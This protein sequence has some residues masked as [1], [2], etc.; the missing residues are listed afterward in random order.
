MVLR[1]LAVA[2]LSAGVML[3][4][5]SHALAVKEVQTKSA[6]GEPFRAEVELT[7]LGDL[8]ANEIR[9]TLASA[10]DFERMGIDRVFF[11]NDLRFDVEVNPGG[12]SFIRITSAKPV[13]EPYLDFV[14][15]IAW[16]GN[17]RLQEVT[18][19]LDPPLIADSAPA[20]IEAPAAA[21]P[22]PTPVP[23]PAP[24]PAPEAAPTSE[25]PAPVVAQ[26]QPRP[27]PAPAPVAPS[28]PVA[29]RPVPVVQPDSYHV[30]AGDT[31]ARIA[32][33]FRGGAS[34]G[35][36][37]IALQ[38]ANPAAFANNNIN[39][40]KRGQVLRIPSEEQMREVSAQEA[41]ASL[42]EQT[43]RWRATVAKAAPKPA[44][45]AAQVD[46][47]AKAEAPKAAPAPASK[48]EMKLLGAEA[49]KAGA[50]TSGK[51]KP[52][53]TKPADA[54][55]LGQVKAQ[56]DSAKAEKEKLAGKVQTLDAKV[57]TNDQKVNVQN[58]RL[59]QLESQLKDAQA[60]A[61][62]TKAEATKAAA[63][64]A[65]ADKAAAAK[66]E[67]DKAAAAKA[68]ADKAAA[69]KAEAD[70]AA[71]DKASADNAAATASPEAQADAAAPAA[72]PVPAP[73]PAPAPAPV[74]AEEP[75]VE[76]SGPLGLII[77]GIAALLAAGGAGWWW[78]RR[79]KE[80]EEAEATLAELES[81]DD[82]AAAEQDG[83][84]AALAQPATEEL[85]DS[86]LAAAEPAAPAAAA[87]RVLADP[88]EE[89]E[90]YIAYER[91]P[92]A[93][94]L[95]TKAIAASPD[96]ADLRMKL[97]EV[98]AHLDDWNGFTEQANWFEQAG[99][100]ESL[101]RAEEL[102]AGMTPPP[103]THD[104]DGLID[105]VSAAPAAAPAAAS[106]SDELPSLED[107][108]MD[109]NSTA[110]NLSSPVLE[111]VKDDD[112][113]LDL[114]AF[115]STPAA[116]PAPV[117]ETS[118]DDGLDDLSFELDHDAFAE[119]AP[120]TAAADDLSFDLN[121]PAPAASGS[122]LGDLTDLDAELAFE[123][124]SPAPAAAAPTQEDDDL[125]FS[126]DDLEVAAEPTGAAD[127]S[128][129]A[130]FGLDAGTTPAAA[131]ELSFD[132]LDTGDLGSDDLALEL[133]ADAGA[134]DEL[135]AGEFSLDEAVDNASLDDLA[136][137]FDANLGAESAAT[138]APAVAAAPAAAGSDLGMDDEF[139]FLADTDENATKLDLAR[140]YIDM[141][142]MEGAR[143]ILQEVLTEGSAPQKDEA[144]GLLA[145]VG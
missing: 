52:S 107:L 78:N 37:M 39:Q 3:P 58:A 123:P 127:L 60:K 100:L 33:R 6:L 138:P 97:L 36:A 76:E 116:A 45:E 72:A 8:N 140:A 68:E 9:V 31:A 5:L 40:L 57:K 54:Q 131:D 119:P 142:D 44:L 132:E 81:L 65:E 124:S 14:V 139:D 15:R 53:A 79:R 56:A 64:K 103:V 50:S 77:G 47:T 67:A 49:G 96:R 98:Y 86:W 118:A 4:G 101:S 125:S 130:D 66:A 114:D 112:F 93:V 90:Q 29:P 71:A 126:L 141:G 61:A 48:P 83:E 13:M 145:Q 136:A 2:L 19:L 27:A 94:G 82:E 129:D 88:L 21:A 69:A 75:P 109:F 55:K 46:A 28:A 87:D 11:L 30:Q 144:R 113:S 34:A 59:A 43:A 41:Q 16:P 137:D 84:F 70:K 143:D 35:Q 95:L 89:A 7:E 24:A 91:Y 73:A 133:G 22:A 92:Q 25:A 62:A 12:R 111:A 106:A 134:A 42:R 26:P 110:T 74:V 122:S 63:A 23:A 80:Q 20:A 17:A 51:D 105:F 32:E 121:E 85:D 10:E 108:E 38:R 117:A 99:D 1:K 120:A 135:S 102:K 18:A 128:L 115:D 104:D